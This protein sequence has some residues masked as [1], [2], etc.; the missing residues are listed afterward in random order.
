MKSKKDSSIVN[1]FIYLLIVV[2]II[3][4]ALPPICRILFK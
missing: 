2:F 4:I 3:L 1:I